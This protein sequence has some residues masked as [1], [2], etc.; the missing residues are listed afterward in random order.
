MLTVPCDVAIPAAKEGTIDGTVAREIRARL[1]V[2]GANGPTT[3]E[4]EHV[5][6]EAGIR[7]VPDLLANAGG[8][9]ASYSEWWQN[10][11]GESWTEADDRAFVLRRLER[12]WDLVAWLDP[13]AWRSRAL[14]IAME[15]V[16][17]AMGP[18]GEHTS[19]RSP[20]GIVATIPV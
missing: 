12:S 10:R 6:H 11:R 14:A 15:R 16:A 1:V 4:A 7:V 18:G 17:S 2:E 3:P 20:D 8:V 5:L 9:I 19:L 13:I